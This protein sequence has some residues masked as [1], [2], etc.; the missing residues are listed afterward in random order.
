MGIARRITGDVD[1]HTV[2]LYITRME[3]LM[4]RMS[5]I[6]QVAEPERFAWLAGQMDELHA[7]LSTQLTALTMEVGTLRRV[8]TGVLVAILVGLVTIPVSIIWAAAMAGNASCWTDG[9]SCPRSRPSRSSG[10]S[11]S[12]TTPRKPST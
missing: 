2:G 12:S 9:F 3:A 6:Q 11:R 1:L 5:E 8:W 4:S 10:S 7:D